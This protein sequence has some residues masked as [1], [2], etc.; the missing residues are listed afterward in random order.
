MITPNHAHIHL[1]VWFRA[2]VLL[3]FTL[4]EPGAHGAGVTGMQ[5]TG[6]ST[7]AASEVAKATAGLVKDEHMPNGGMLAMGA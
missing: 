2:G 4:E 5:G 6:V 1:E 7:P 3:I